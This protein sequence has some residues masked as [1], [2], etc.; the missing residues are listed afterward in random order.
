MAFSLCLHY[1]LAQDSSPLRVRV[2]YTEQAITIDG[3]M[4]EAAWEA[5]GTTGDFWQWFPTD[6]AKAAYQT[7]IFMLYDD[8]TLYV[9][10]KCHSI[11]DAYI[12][13]SLRRDYRAGGNDNFTLVFDTFNDGRNAYVFGVNP[14]G[15]Q[16]EALIANGGNQS[17]DFNVSWDNKWSADAQRYDGYW[18]AECA[19]PFRTLRYNEGATA[20][21]FNSYRFDTQTN[22]R[23]TW[24]RVPRNQTVMNLAFMGTMEWEKPLG[25][26][27]GNVSLIPYISGGMARD[28]EEGTPSERDFGIGGDAKIAVTAGLNLDLT[29]NPDFS[30]VEVDQQVANLDRFEIFFPERRQFFL[31]NSDLFASFGNERIRPFFSR[32]IGVA[33]DTATGQNIENP[34]LLGARLNG[35]LDD[36]WR[37]GLLNMQ[38][39][40]EEEGGLPSYNFTVGAL[41]R[42]I[43]SRSSLAFIFVNKQAFSDSLGDFSVNPE[44]YGFHRLVG[45]EFNLSSNDN[46]WNGKIFYHHSLDEKKSARAFAH[47]MQMDYLSRDI[48]LSWI[49]EWVGDG[50][51]APVGFVPRN[52][53]FRIKPQVQLIAYGK[54]G[55]LNQHGPGV[56]A[57]IT[58]D[59]VYDYTDHIM[60]L[61]YEIEFRDNST[62]RASIQNTYTY[63]FN[64]FDPSRTEAKPLP[65]FTDYRYTALACSLRTDQ[66]KIIS[67]DLETYLGEFFN[68]N[69]GG[70]DGTVTWRYQPL[71]ALAMNISYN[72]IDLPEDYASTHVWLVGPRIDLT[73]TRSLFLTTFFQYNSQLENININTRFQWRFKPA[74]DFFLVYTDN[75]FASDFNIRTRALVAKLSYWLNI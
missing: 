32:R 61:F 9:A 30:Q 44:A 33:R 22:E 1:A 23:S 52:G 65:A 37:I 63:L 36:N 75:Y 51:D 54:K 50:F 55:L 45:T 49:H 4:D 6:S 17:S 56:A 57:D 28:Y 64:D 42:K 26:P 25:K 34:I 15:V 31:E 38:T 11:G 5:A 13:P 12:T 47:G 20:W 18:I 72:Y 8:A 39:A 73:F 48:G 27:G 24:A 66:R 74:S 2:A 69:R 40:K 46:K 53:F 16:R 62:L 70:V 29:I 3:R 21:R 14:F 19:I 58:W 43:F 7:E 60:E 71:G 35:K 59:K 10:A 67:A 68:G 41:Q